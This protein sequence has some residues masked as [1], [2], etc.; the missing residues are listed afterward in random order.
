MSH[1]P[2]A[3]A[4]PPRPP[5]GGGRTAPET[6]EVK[7][8]PSG[9]R[10]RF[11]RLA[12]LAVLLVVVGAAVAVLAGSGYLQP[13]L[14]RLWEKVEGASAQ[15]A[16]QHQE[17]DEHPRLLRDASGRLIQP[18]VIELTLEQAASLNISPATIVKA[19]P[20]TK[21]RPLPAMDGQLA[22]DSE[23]LYQ[24]RPRFAGEVVQFGPV[25][26]HSLLE[27]GD[28]EP[29]HVSEHWQETRPVGVGDYVKKG[30]LLVVLWSRDLGDKKAAL[31]DAL[32][33]LR[34]D[35][36]R[37]EKL[38]KGWEEGVIPE[39]M[40][41]EAQR[42]VRKDQSAANAAERSLRT[43]KMTDEEIDAI[44]QEAAKIDES[45]RDPKREQN[46]ARVE[47]QAPHAGIIVEKNTNIGD[48][49]DP[50]ASPAAMFRLADLSHLAVWANAREEYRLALQK[51]MDENRN[52]GRPLK[53]QIRLLAEPDTP[54]LEG[55][56]LRVAPSLDPTQRTM[57]VIGR[58]DNP[59]RRLLV[60]QSITATVLVRPGPG[61]VE[62][63]TEA[64]NEQDGQ[65][66]VFVQPDPH[67]LQFVLRRIAVTSRFQDVVFVRSE[68]RKAEEEES[69][70]EAAKGRRP[71]LP[72]RP[73]ER[74]VTRSV[75]MLTTA[76]RDLLANAGKTGAGE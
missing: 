7:P 53:W 58:V 18:P 25:R 9:R 57:L 13:V 38:K 19:E 16:K 46:W 31:I 71:I 5:E 45:K 1:R 35:K 50:A 69:A 66:L 62:I 22:Y 73:G 37:L 40:Y 42:T 67:K 44:K 76:V 47:V 41:Y 64:L 75:T 65:S 51:V 43:S 28:H 11:A 70:Q 34:R 29:G 10:R 52:E 20:A 59:G 54:P 36:Q 49:V 26:P 27:D 33:D 48:W 14:D 8:G 24:V 6:A 61:Q 2:L 74:V 12:V 56:I 4:L 39:S 15:Q 32:I 21:P 63:P 23:G 60:G 3:T 72:L 55:P 68:L 17:K 30:D